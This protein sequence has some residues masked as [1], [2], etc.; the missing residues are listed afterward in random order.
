MQPTVECVVY[1]AQVTV[2][3]CHVQNVHDLAK[4]FTQNFHGSDALVCILHNAYVH[5]YYQN[6]IFKKIVNN[7]HRDYGSFLGK[8]WR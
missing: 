6:V 8:R 3:L 5:W 4:M 2:V 7:R 1:V